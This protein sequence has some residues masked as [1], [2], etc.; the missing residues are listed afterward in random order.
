MGAARGTATLAAPNRPFGVKQQNR[1]ES[2][3]LGFWHLAWPALSFW[4]LREALGAY[5]DLS[6]SASVDGSDPGY[7][8]W[9]ALEHTS[10]TALA[11]T[12]LLWAMI[13]PSSGPTH[14]AAQYD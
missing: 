2:P 7:W 11:L 5:A 4:L 1:P 12:L 13:R 8:L 6:G 10:R 3:A 14:G 9:S